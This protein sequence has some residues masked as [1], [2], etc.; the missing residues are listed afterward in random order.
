MIQ[1]NWYFRG[2]KKRVHDTLVITNWKKGRVR[3]NWLRITCNDEYIKT[4]HV[5][6]WPFR[7]PSINYI[8]S[9]RIF[10]FRLAALRTLASHCICLD[11]LFTWIICDIAC[12]YPWNLYSEKWGDKMAWQIKWNKNRW[13]SMLHP[14]SIFFLHHLC[15][16]FNK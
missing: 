3:T 5:V 1:F 12:Q 6:C 7:N 15:F 4:C 9:M 10:L 16:C 13:N 11:C 2:K 14:I 8:S